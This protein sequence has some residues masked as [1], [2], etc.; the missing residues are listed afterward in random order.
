LENILLTTKEAAE[1]LGIS[2]RRVI[3]LIEAGDLR[4]Q[5]FGRAWM[6][7]E[8][9]VQERLKVPRL[10]GRPKLGERNPG[11]LWRYTLMN[12][13]HAVFD[14]VYNSGN[15]TVGEVT[16]R[17]G[18]DYAPLGTMSRPGHPTPG[19]TSDWLSNRYI[20]TV[21]PRLKEALREFAVEHQVQLLFAS[22]GLNLSDQYW[23]APEGTTL[24]WHD[25]NYFEN[26]YDDVLG[27]SLSDENDVLAH[28]PTT[29]PSSG[30]PGVLPKWWERRKGTDVLIKG[31]DL[32]NREPYNEL[33]ATRLYETLLDK[34]DFTPYSLEISATTGRPF[35]I[36]PCFIDSSTE[37]VTMY[38][39]M[40]CFAHEHQR[41]DYWRYRDTCLQ[42]GV[43][44]IERQLAKLIVC[45]FLTANPDRHDRNLGL[46]REV[47]TL[48]F[49]R[50]APIFDNGRAF[51]YAAQRPDE[52]LQRL[53][54]YQSTP[55]SEYPLAQLALVEDY[56]WY[57]PDRLNGFT[58]TIRETLAANSRLPE[59]LIEAMAIQ[60]DRR[61]QR[62]NEA[63]AEHRPLSLPV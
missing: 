18:I 11:K 32:N 17:E 58:N 37:L 7:D 8:A 27:R 62:V 53:F 19:Q 22:Y 29:S 36:C 59:P 34:N 56:D 42:L 16:I 9:S 40:S 47:E 3:A 52:L 5:R 6:I 33:L 38:D 35:S 41:Y 39:V 50:V 46:I 54:F 4:A 45:D 20:P 48:T 31:G 57:E 43:L 44:D 2:A 23:F 24:D 28:P 51:Y 25:I 14:L 61:L 55:F 15:H 60:F 30:T 49:T 12:R 10:T 63:A 1:A 26:G 21:R 13:N